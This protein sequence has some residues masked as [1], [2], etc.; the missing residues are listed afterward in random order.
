MRL[1]AAVLS[2]VAALLLA[3]GTLLPYKF[4]TNSTGGSLQTQ[5]VE[6]TPWKF[7]ISWVSTGTGTTG[8]VHPPYFGIPILVVA[9]ALLVSVALV[10]RRAGSARVTVV[11]TATAAAAILA[12]MLTDIT[13]F[14][15]AYSVDSTA[16]A[17]IAV[18]AGSGVW[19]LSAGTAAAVLAA[20]FVCL[21]SRPAAVVADN[22]DDTDTPPMGFSA[23]VITALRTRN[24]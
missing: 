4:L 10:V 9:V 6:T 7:T 22:T 17:K 23:P 16:G 11:A 20:V 14:L 8:N 5:R 2:G 12:M 13:A 21:R 3:V 1:I 24:K 19:V 15:S 18:G